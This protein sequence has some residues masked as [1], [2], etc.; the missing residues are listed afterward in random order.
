MKIFDLE[1][2]AAP[3][4][5]RLRWPRRSEVSGDDAAP[6]GNQ[7]YQDLTATNWADVSR[8]LEVEAA[9]VRRVEN[10][11]DPSGEESRIEVELDTQRDDDDETPLRGLDLGVAAAV[12]VLAAVGAVPVASCNGGAFGRVHQGSNPY[13]ACYI[14]PRRYITVSGWAVRAGLVPIVTDDGA[15]VLHAREIRDLL[16]FSELALD[17]QAQSVDRA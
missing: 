16:R 10:A 3:D 13:V 8:V 17:D 7:H 5:G 1:T 15:L 6:A 4:P 12:L 2:P 9:L 14:R 11:S